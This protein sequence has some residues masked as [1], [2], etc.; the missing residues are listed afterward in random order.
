MHFHRT[1]SAIICINWKNNT[2]IKANWSKKCIV[3]DPHNISLHVMVMTKQC[4]ITAPER[5]YLI[6]KPDMS[7]KNLSFGAT[8]NR[9]DFCI[10][11]TRTV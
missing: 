10:I 8:L 4:D 9:T 1:L 5:S 6:R 11:Y 2:P 7:T 3:F